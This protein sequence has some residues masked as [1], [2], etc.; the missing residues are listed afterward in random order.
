MGGFS[1]GL[2]GCAF[3][4][5]ENKF[6]ASFLFMVGLFVIC[7]F[8]YNLYTGKVC[9][10]FENNL[11]YLINIPV[12]WLGNLIG[13]WL[14]GTL[15]VHTRIAAPIIE[16]AVA[17]VGTKFG[18]DYVSIFILAIFCNLMICIG[19]DG[20]KNNPHELGK[21]L[22]LL[23]GVVIFVYC[24]FEHCIANMFYITVA[25]AWSGKALVFLLVCTIG[26]AVGGWIIPVARNWSKKLTKE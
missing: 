1:I 17:V 18:D 14:S 10:I 26:N 4:L 25:G 9:Y 19:V 3:L 24:G 15:L 20:Y 22:S 7:T 5:T 2:G 11:S 21:Y 12:I 23:F 6:L 8:G 13:T 16:K